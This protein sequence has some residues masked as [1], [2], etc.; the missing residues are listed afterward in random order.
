MN[1]NGLC[2]GLGLLRVILTGQNPT[3]LP[4]TSLFAGHY[5][6]TVD[7]SRFLHRDIEA[8]ADLLITGE[9]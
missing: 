7:D 1:L 3:L 5:P 2:A 6:E 4:G 9:E 8:Q